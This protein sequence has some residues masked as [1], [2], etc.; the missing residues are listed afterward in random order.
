MINAIKKL[1]TRII[2]SI[3]FGIYFGEAI[4]LIT[5]HKR[6]LFDLNLIATLK[7]QHIF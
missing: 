6:K 1:Y 3:H 2:K 5:S 4:E 7:T